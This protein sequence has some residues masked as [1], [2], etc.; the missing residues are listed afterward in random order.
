MFLWLIFLLALLWGAIVYHHLI[1][2]ILMNRF[3]SRSIDSTEQQPGID[4]FKNIAILIPA[5]NEAAY[6]ADKIR[7]VASLNYPAEKIKLYIACDGC[8]DNTPELARITAAEWQASDLNIQVIEFKR[9]HGKVAILNKLIPEIDADVI[10]LSDASALISIDALQLANQHF[11]NQDVGVVAATYKILNPGSEGERKYWDYQTNIKRGESAIGSPIGVH[12][13]LY[14]FRKK[15]FEPLPTDT[16]NDDFILPMQIVSKGYKSIYDCELVAVELE[17]ASLDM[18]QKRRLRIA[19][20]NF[21]QLIR[22]PALFSP[23]LKGTAFSFISGKALRALM[24]IIL[25]FQF[26]ICLGLG[27]FN[28][29]FL[30]ISFLQ[31]LVF[32]LARL[33]LL[34][35]DRSLPKG[36]FFKPIK[37][38]FYLVNGYWSSLIGTLRYMFGLDRNPWKSV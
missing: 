27:V 9:N 14:F 29:I 32:L 6:I 4:E 35:P 28:E 25:M 20:G 8:Q 38:I 33:S 11:E 3:A 13:A 30:V 36:G 10:A 37:L 31:L 19:A 7:N 12:G 17:V 26:L 5:Y 24:P 15:L 34:I 1:Y 2:P 22:I 21:Q 18:D 16:I 23:K